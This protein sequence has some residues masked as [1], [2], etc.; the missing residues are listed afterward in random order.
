MKHVTGTILC[1]VAAVLCV[2]GV[3]SGRWIVDGMAG[4]WEGV[5]S[6]VVESAELSYPVFCLPI[7]DAWVDYI[8]KASTN[9]FTNICYYVRSTATNQYTTDSSVWTYFTDDYSPDIR[10]WHYSPP[11]V[12]IYSQLANPTYSLV[13][14]V[15]VYPS[16]D[17]LGWTNWMS[18]TNTSLIWS[19]ARCDAISIEMNQTGNKEHWNPCVPVSWQSQRTRP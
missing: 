14:F 10:A 17:A 4:Q 8:L 13:S 5:P 6:L 2:V 9:N 19:Y 16:H 18:S 1:G 3:S 7:G 12:S 11:G 15:M